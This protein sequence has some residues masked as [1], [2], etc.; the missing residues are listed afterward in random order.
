MFKAPAFKTRTFRAGTSRIT[1]LN[2][3]VAAALLAGVA[4]VAVAAPQSQA[5]P[6]ARAT[7]DANGDGA[8]DRGEA[9]KSQRL[10]GKF[11]QL[12]RNLDGRLSADERPKGKGGHG[13]GHG[14]RGGMERLDKDADGRISRAEFDA[15]QAARAQRMA[16]KG[17]AAGRVGKP[18][19]DFAAADANRDGQL[20]RSEL[21]AYHERTRPQ[22]EAESAQRHA[23]RFAAA[24]INKDGKLSRLEVGEKMP[25]LEKSFA[26]MDENRD[27]F[28]S[29][30]EL[31]PPRKR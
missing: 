16:G 29:R 12:D 13:R 31:Q 26:W 15:G 30:T 9:A 19:L 8:I 24:D 5:A 23:E 6:R 17:D 21:R 10:A 2:A 18:M 11:D 4:T 3:A 20:V 14:K 7:L 1:L 22:R 28:L 27:G 25:R